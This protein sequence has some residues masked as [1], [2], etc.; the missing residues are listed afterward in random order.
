MDV[1]FEGLVEGPELEAANLLFR[2]S[3]F[4]TI[5][6]LSG[7]TKGATPAVTLTPII[8]T[9]LVEDWTEGFC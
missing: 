1:K 6:P 2:K 3:T 8:L 7:A 5:R 4:H 9:N